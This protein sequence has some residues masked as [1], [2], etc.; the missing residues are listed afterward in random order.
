M[1]ED[2]Y[3]LQNLQLLTWSCGHC[4]YVAGP[5]EFLISAD[6]HDTDNGTLGNGNTIVRMFPLCRTWD[7][8]LKIRS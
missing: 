2:D 1:S 7:H 8:Q 5:T 6:L 3:S 4:I